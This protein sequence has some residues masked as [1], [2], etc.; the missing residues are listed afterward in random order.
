MIRRLALP[1]VA[2]AALAAAGCGSDTGS[3]TGAGAGPLALLDLAV[4]KGD[5]A[6]SYRSDLSM[7]STMR[8]E[9]M[10]V[11]GSFT[12]NADSTRVRMTMTMKEEGSE[13][14]E[15]EAIMVGDEMYVKYDGAELGLPAGKQWLR[16]QDKT[17]ATPTLSPSK[18]VRFLRDS[19]DVK[20]V[21]TE[22]IR[23]EMTT[24]FRGPLNPEKLAKEI[25]EEAVEALG[26]AAE[27]AAVTIDVWVAPSG[28]PSRV[29][30]EVTM[31]GKATG[32]VKVTSE[33]LEYGVPVNADEPPKGQVAEM[34]EIGS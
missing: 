24:H 34:S 25:G 10:S 6:E 30:A 21:G 9:V 29:G 26:P 2:A 17:L 8:G 12:S 22:E 23:G 5:D 7:E 18:F 28:L 15:F 33:V 19:G 31:P 3:G 14:L 11:Q 1:F 13:P 4:E 20:V 27:G 32:S 16:M